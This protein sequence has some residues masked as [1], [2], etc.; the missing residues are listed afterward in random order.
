MII[1]PIGRI[2]EAFNKFGAQIVPISPAAEGG[3]FTNMMELAKHNSDVVFIRAVKKANR[4][5]RFIKPF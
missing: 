4:C 3:N 2:L 5:F 1:I